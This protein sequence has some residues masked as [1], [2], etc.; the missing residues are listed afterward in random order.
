M[1]YNRSKVGFTFFEAVI[2]LTIIA[3]FISVFF[4]FYHQASILAKEKVLQVELKGLRMSLSLY[5]AT[6]GH[7]PQD[8]REL[9][10]ANYKMATLADVL[11][12]SEYLSTISTDK[13]GFPVDVFGNRYHYDP[14]RGDVA[15]ATRDYQNW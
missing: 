2:S 9:I 10:S 15:S 5:K 8:L 7:Y 1:I 11:F 6:Q 13:E 4:I 12:K 3:V 14:Y